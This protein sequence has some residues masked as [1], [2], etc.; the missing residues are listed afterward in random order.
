MKI[1]LTGFIFNPT[2]TEESDLLMRGIT[3]K[4]ELNMTGEIIHTF[5][6]I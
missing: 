2:H 4:S 6:N 5:T 1:S 3:S